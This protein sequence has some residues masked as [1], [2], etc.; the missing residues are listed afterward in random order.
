METCRHLERWANRKDSPIKQ[1]PKTGVLS[2]HIGDASIITPMHCVMCGGHGDQ[3]NPYESHEP[4]CKCGILDR[5][6]E[7]AP[8]FVEFETKFNEYHLLHPQRGG[9]SMLYF[10]PACGGQLPLS[11]RGDFFTKPTEEDRS[12]V[13]ETMQS[14]IT[15][16][17]MLRT[18]G[19]PTHTFRHCS[20]DSCGHKAQYTYAKSW[21]SLE[22]HVQE[23]FDGSLEFSWGGKELEDANK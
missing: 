6:I 15:V 23:Q 8:N 21:E 7:T 14:I 12:S 22:L 4:K 1:D 11:C 18:L 16:E 13:R 17:D 19:E 5:L 3:I 2:L 20:S 10:C 9:Y